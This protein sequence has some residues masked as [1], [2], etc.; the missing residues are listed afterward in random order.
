[1]MFMLRSIHFQIER[2]QKIDVS[3]MNQ[4]PP[5]AEVRGSNPFGRANKIRGFL[6][7][8]FRANVIASE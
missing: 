3:Q 8:E 6:N 1:M 7:S 2:A 5:K 4:N